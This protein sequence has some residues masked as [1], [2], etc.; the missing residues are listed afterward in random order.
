MHAPVQLLHQQGEKPVPHTQK[1][2]FEQHPNCGQKPLY[3][4]QESRMAP[5]SLLRCL[6]CSAGKFSG[7][8]ES[9]RA[10]LC[11]TPALRKTHGAH[12]EQTLVQASAQ[13]S[14]FWAMSWLL[15]DHVLSKLAETQR[16]S[17]P[18]DGM[19]SAGRSR[20]EGKAESRGSSLQRAP[21]PVIPPLSSPASSPLEKER[22][23][24]CQEAPGDS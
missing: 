8:D 17:R 22:A 20:D 11:S 10:R 4:E 9:C 18:S 2:C 13:R 24:R 3:K 12:K 6:G 16:S 19:L 14:S 23:A 5:A 1:D 21:F 15:L 7:E